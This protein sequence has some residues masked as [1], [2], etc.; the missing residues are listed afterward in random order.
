MTEEADSRKTAEELGG[1]LASTDRDVKA[2]FKASFLFFCLRDADDI[3]TL[4]QPGRESIELLDA[5]NARLDEHDN[6]LSQMQDPERIFDMIKD[7]VQPL[8][9]S[10]LH[11][12]Q[13]RLEDTELKLNKVLPAM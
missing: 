11:R 10:D 8:I 4:G 5:I 13:S 2:S 7:H 1:S 3:D 9:A 12:L 6:S